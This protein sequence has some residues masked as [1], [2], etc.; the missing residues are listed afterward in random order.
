LGQQGR[1]PQ[2][3]QL[4][5]QLLEERRRGFLGMQQWLLGGFV[6]LVPRMGGQGQQLA[7][8][9]GFRHRIFL[10]EPFCWKLCDYFDV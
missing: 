8:R 9:D 6:A 7:L 3:R 5:Q 2:G 1:R 4:V 10:D